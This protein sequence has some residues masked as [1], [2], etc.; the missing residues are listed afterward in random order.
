MSAGP[1]VIRG[2]QTDKGTDLMPIRVQPETLLLEI[3]GVANAP[4][5]GTISDAYGSARVGGGKFQNGL[6][7]RYVRIKFTAA[8]AGYKP[9][10]PITLPILN[11]T[12]WAGISKGDTGTYLSTAI[13]VVGVPQPESRA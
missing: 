8:L 1:F 5:T 3:G 11:P 10:A 13:I 6:K 12:V 4:P 7:A 9:D 2:Y